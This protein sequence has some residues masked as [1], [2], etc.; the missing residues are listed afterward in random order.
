MIENR[1]G[2]LLIRSVTWL[3]LAALAFGLA[4]GAVLFS[5][6]DGRIAALW[7]LN[8]FVVVVLLRRPRRE[9]PLILSAMLAGNLSANF[10]VGD[11]VIR[12]VLLAGGNLSEVTVI[13]WFLGRQSRVRLSRR[14]GLF[15]FMRASI[16]GC[17]VSVV[18]ATT[19]LVIT[20]G[21]PPLEGALL[22]VAAHFLGLMVF[23]P[24][25]STVLEGRALKVLRDQP[26]RSAALLSAVLLIVAP[27][28]IQTQFPLLFV[29]PVVLVFVCFQLELAATA[30]AMLVVAMLAVLITLAGFGPI[31]SVEGS[32]ALKVFILQFYLGCL[33]LMSLTVAGAVAERRGLI[34]RLTKARRTAQERG[35]RER[36]LLDH[37]RLSEDLSNVGY[38]THDTSTGEVFWSPG[39]YRIHGVDPDAFKP[40]FDNALDF[41][42]EE[43]RRRAAHMIADCT[44][45]GTGWSFDGTFIRQADGLPRHVS[46][47]AACRKDRNNKV[48]GFFGVFKDLTDER[49]MVAA[50]QEARAEA[51]AALSVKTT[52][53]ANMSH[54]I[55][56]PLNGVL[57][58]ADLLSRT[59]LE[60][61]QISYVERIRTAGRGLSLLIDDIL[62]FSRLEAGKLP[63]V[64]RDFDLGSLIDEV[65]GLI[66]AGPTG[67]R[68][69]FKV[70]LSPNVSRVLHGDAAR[71]RQV[72]LNVIGNAAK[73]TGAGSVAISADLEE[74]MVKL[75]ITDTGPG[76][77]PDRLA[78]LFAG[79][80][81][82]DSSISRRY[83]GSG[84]GLSISRSLARLMG[85]DLTME[86]PVG[87]GAEVTLTLPHV[88]GDT[89]CL[90]QDL[91]APSGPAISG[92]SPLRIMVVDDVEMNRELVEIALSQ[93][94]HEIIGFDSASDAIDALSSGRP[95]DM[96]LMDV[97]MP[98][99]DGL[100]ATRKIR[101]LSGSV[102]EVPIIGLTAQAM[103]E[104]VAA[105]RE[106]GM[107]EHLAKP[108]DLGRLLRVVEAVTSRR[109]AGDAN[110]AS[111]DEATTD[112]L[113]ALS[114][115]YAEHLR[116]MPQEIA[117]LLSRPDL[118][119]RAAG[120][121]ALA[122]SA[123]GTAGS[124]GFAEVSE[125]A[126]HLEAVAK[127]VVA[128]RRDLKDL[129]HGIAAFEAAVE[130]A[131]A[132]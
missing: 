70:T 63:L 37:A 26:V 39:V 73:F 53:L 18:F 9:W 104:Q 32:L 109:V 24:P 74:G 5:R 98:D 20:G 85:G 19:A 108:I 113:A 57:G 77:A 31:S 30:M 88:P 2:T 48:I 12:A 83:G 59:S 16:V 117:N 50:L 25:F 69:E 81:Q 61:D 90:D 7:P 4:W 79:F 103:P 106:A 36:A 27:T 75:V 93:A 8:A 116:A 132:S 71:V 72:L 96:V 125:A 1:I 67:A 128:G 110:S 95:F 14:S 64:A 131:A 56:T 91:E 124:L 11:G 129:D 101:A 119:D 78:S 65:V 82:A 112:A 29:A 115:R 76:V 43:D 28:L 122:H 35:L 89:L 17:G 97:Q 118:V 60:G 40:S 62:D 15:R 41:Y 49:L 80:T 87:R 52:F 130:H 54:E 105:C 84:L 13:A 55:R 58:F 68:I 86:S 42:V 21:N 66:A 123:A 33:S 100:T 22:W 94:G 102:A 34:R 126:F 45:R 3:G 114:M 121:A 38:W 6:D 44:A 23:A 10:A 107:D 46:A 92:G 47:L 99:I 111:Q 127:Q 120:L 51:E